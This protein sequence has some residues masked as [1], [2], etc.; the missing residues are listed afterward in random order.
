MSNV[1][2]RERITQNRVIRLFQDKLGYEYLGNWEKRA[3]NRNIEPDYLSAW[4]RKQHV[5][6][7]L[8]DKTLQELARDNALDEG[9]NLYTPIRINF[10]PSIP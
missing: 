4:L 2:D 5:S 6:D 3:N 7:T 9:N 8:I 10:K 1:S